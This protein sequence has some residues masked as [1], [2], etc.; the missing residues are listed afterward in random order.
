[1][2]GQERIF[3]FLAEP[4]T[5]GMDAPVRRIDTHCAAVFL[6][7][8]DVFKVKKAV[9]YPFLDFSTLAQRRQACEAELAVNR[10]NA[11]E[12]Y[13]GLV[14]ITEEEGALRLGGTGPVVEWAVHLRR[15]DETATLDRL[16]DRGPLGEALAGRLAEAVLAAHARAPVVE[17][18]TAADHLRGILT[19]TVE[20][21]RA[22]IGPLPAEDVVRFAELAGAAYDRQL[23][24]LRARAAVGFLRRCH[25]D[26]HLG[27]IVLIEERPVLFDAIEFDPAIAT[28]DI[29]Y[30]LAFLLMDLWERGQ[31]AEANFLCGTYLAHTPAPLAQIEGLAALPFFMAL[32]AA[33]RA[34]VLLAQSRL[35]GGEGRAVEARRYLALALT[36]LEPA[37]PLL[38]ALGGFSGSGKTRL[39]QA[40]APHLGRLPG[41]VHLRSDVL[42]KAMLG[43]DETTRLGNDAYRPAVNGQV[44]AALAERARVALRTGYSVIL[45][46]T[47]REPAAREAAEDLAASLGLPFL[48]LWLEAPAEVLAARVAARK[49][50]ASDATEAVLQAQLAEGTGPLRW[51]PLDA[52]QPLAH[53]AR[54]A[55]QRAAAC[56]RQINA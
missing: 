19:D 29:L 55:S 26:L 4:R 1:M 36:C 5:H 3:A 46:A 31:R 12:L 39:G 44:R 51:V 38:V 52:T 40:L 24:L 17:D 53:L 27:N 22:G 7:G 14:P 28:C 45:D 50:D 48:G 25:G 32:R 42:R 6:A 9:R 43:V 41:A 13:L 11:P 8:P 35:G 33:I 18:L 10:A 20:E 37:P 15:F 2:A 21:L 30:D 56:L 47:H 54:E 49:G 34:K 23:P 16:A